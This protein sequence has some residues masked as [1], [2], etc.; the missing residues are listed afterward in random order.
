VVT[1]S[2]AD[3]LETEAVYQSLSLSFD[4]AVMSAPSRS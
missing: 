3:G 2:Q 1:V 4:P